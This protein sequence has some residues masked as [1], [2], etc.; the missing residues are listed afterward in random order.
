MFWRSKSK[1]PPTH[2][3]YSRSIAMVRRT[4][5]NVDQWLCVWDT[6]R[7]Y[8]DFVTAEP[9][10][11]QSYRAAIQEQVCDTLSLSKRDL[12]VSSMAQLNLEYGDTLPDTK[13]PTHISV[14]FFQVH[15]YSKF[16]RSHVEALPNVRW[17]SSTE[18][19]HGQTSDGWAISETLTYL[20]R[21]SDVIPHRTA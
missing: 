10:A 19:L 3:R 14:S 11:G 7:N 5:E 4:D 16:S 18:L 15:L 1:T 21:R 2:A 13:Q 8:Y 20:L 12:L 17:T 6:T 9:Q